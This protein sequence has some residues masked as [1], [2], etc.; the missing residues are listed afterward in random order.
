MARP[1]KNAPKPNTQE[2]SLVPVE[3]QP[4]PLPEGWKWVR[5]GDV[6]S[7]YNGDRGKNYPSKK[8]YISNG[9]AFVNAGSIEDGRV[10][11]L[12]VNFISDEKF[13]ALNAGKI[14][15]ND[16]LYCL[17]GS[18]GK[19]ALV[20]FDSR[21]AISSSLCIL[22]GHNCITQKYIFYI[23]Q[24]VAVEHTENYFGIF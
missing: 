5:L 17:R 9:P 18:I 15:N 2:L 4:Y 1:R 22:R 3:E 23:M 24:S 10:N 21:A 7:L 8:D 19:T 14:K 12:N 6:I 13:N 20:D 11:F 16:V